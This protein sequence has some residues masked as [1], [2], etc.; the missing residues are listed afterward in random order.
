MTSDN[1]QTERYLYKYAST[2]YNG[3]FKYYS[4]YIS[5]VAREFAK[6]LRV[7]KI[8]KFMFLRFTGKFEDSHDLQT[9]REIFAAC[10]E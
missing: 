5:G 2:K 10:V 8:Y 1:F 4:I 9:L 3:L 6:V 7:H